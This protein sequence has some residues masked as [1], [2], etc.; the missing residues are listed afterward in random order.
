MWETFATLKEMGKPVDFIYLPDA[1]H[2]IVKPWEQ[3]LAQQGLVD[4][5]S[6]WLS[7]E[8]SGDKSKEDQYSRWR[9][10]RYGLSLDR[11]SGATDPMSEK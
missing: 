10:L 8:E 11:K 3:K 4:W 7:G 1:P 9:E 5:F 6:F 2:M